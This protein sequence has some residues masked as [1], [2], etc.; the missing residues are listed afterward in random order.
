MYF[1][2]ITLHTQY[3]PPAVHVHIQYVHVHTMYNICTVH[4]ICVLHVCTVCVPCRWCL[5]TMC[6]WMRLSRLRTQSAYGPSR[7]AD[8][9]SV[10]MSTCIAV[11][12]KYIH[13]EKAVG[14]V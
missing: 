10:Y 3:S 9:E 2:C 4:Y 12:L 7:M 6:R 14:K 11:T 1:S 13:T 5:P 8:C